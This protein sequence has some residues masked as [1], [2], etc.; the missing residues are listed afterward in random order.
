[1][2]RGIA[3]GLVDL[4]VPAAAKD[5]NSL[6]TPGEEQQIVPGNDGDIDPETGGHEIRGSLG[7]MWAQVPA[8][9]CRPVG[10]GTIE[11]LRGQDV[12]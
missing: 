11:L 3:R 2:I 7:R 5:A 1:M 10:K 8:T 9:K 6:A 12:K 4:N